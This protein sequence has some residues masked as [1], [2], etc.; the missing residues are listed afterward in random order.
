M[1]PQKDLGIADSVELP[2]KLGIVRTDDQL[3]AICQ[4]RCKAYARH[5][6]NF[7]VSLAKPEV[8]DT[9][10]G[11]LNLFIQDKATNQIIGTARLQNNLFQP[12][13]MSSE[14]S[15]PSWLLRS[16]SAEITRF[17]V[18]PEFS[19]AHKL[20]SKVLVKACYH[21]CFAT[22]IGWMVIAARRSLVKGYLA[23][24]F[25]DLD[26]EGS[27][28]PLHHTG[29]ILHRPLLL[30]VVSAERDWYTS[31]NVDYDFMLRTYHSDIELFSS[32]SSVWTRGRRNQVV[33]LPP[34]DAYPII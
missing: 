2:F 29:N 20:I 26:P 4:V 13:A 21:Y 33:T 11:V 24:G 31:R 17:A 34:G 3:S 28:F 16:P 9:L 5:L 32:I 8:F 7:A 30:D 25:R 22:Q 6:P 14:F 15:L 19:N 10:P 18:L 23:M 27:Y 12:L 1:E